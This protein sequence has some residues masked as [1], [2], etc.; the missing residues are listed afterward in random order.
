MS[1]DD[2]IKSINGVHERAG[3]QISG[4]AFRGWMIA[5]AEEEKDA[6]K[7]LAR[8]MDKIDERIEKVDRRIIH[9]MEKHLADTAVKEKAY[10]D[11]LKP[12]EE[13]RAQALV[14]GAAVAI[15]FSALV[16]FVLAFLR[17]G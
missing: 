11:R 3:A 1:L 7:E 14:L 17:H 13:T 15:I 4:D 12:L 6:R 8:R 16:S 9:V 2:A 10:N 5:K